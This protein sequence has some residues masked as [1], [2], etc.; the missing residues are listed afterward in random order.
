MTGNM[1]IRDKEPMII[2]MVKVNRN[3]KNNIIIMIK[4]IIKLEM[5]IIIGIINIKIIKIETIKIGTIK[6]ETIK[7]ETI[8]IETIKIETIKIINI[9]I[10]KIEVMEKEG[11]V[12][13]MIG[14]QI[15]TQKKIKITIG[16]N[17]TNISIKEIEVQ[18]QK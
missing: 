5:N 7:I 12:Q 17:H 3:I 6:I 10:I 8:K 18:Q 15:K 13:I 14:T 11:T 16:D 9:E 2:E 4:E 1:K